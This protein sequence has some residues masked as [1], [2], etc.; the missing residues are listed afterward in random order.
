LFQYNAAKDA[1]ERV[2]KDNPNHA[3]VLQQLGWLYHQPSATFSNQ[4]TAISYLTKSLEADPADAKSWYLLGRAFMEGQK[5]NKAYEAYQQA[6][7]RDGKNPT[8]WCSIGVLYYQIN[9]YRDALDAYSR[10]IRLNP[11]ISE[12]WFNLGSLYE[13]CNNQVND[14]IDAYARA[15]DLDPTNTLIKTRLTMLRNAE[16]DGITLTDPPPPQDVHPTAYAQ[17]VANRAFPGAQANNG[18]PPAPFEGALGPSPEEAQPVVNGRDLAAPPPT[19]TAPATS[20]SAFRNGGGPPPLQMTSDIRGPASRPPRTFAPMDMDTR[21]RSTAPRP[22]ASLSGRSGAGEDEE[23]TVERT[24]A[25]SLHGRHES[26]Y[27]PGSSS[28]AVRQ[29]EWRERSDRA[30]S[31]Y[32]PSPRVSPTASRA[33]AQYASRSTL[34]SRLE[35]SPRS[36][37]R[38]PAFDYNRHGST[39]IDVRH[40]QPHRQSGDRLSARDVE[41][42]ARGTSTSRY[43]E[44]GY[45]AERLRIDERRRAELE[46]SRAR[47]E[48][49]RPMPT[50]DSRMTEDVRKTSR[51]PSPARPVSSH[52]RPG[53]SRRK[54]KP[55]KA[56]AAEKQE[57]EAE[58]ARR[59]EAEAAKA[60]PPK[61]VSPPRSRVIDEGKSV[62]DDALGFLADFSQTTM[63]VPPTLSWVSLAIG[64][65][66]K[67]KRVHTSRSSLCPLDL[68]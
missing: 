40:A 61:P 22:A 32:H 6:V 64:A 20:E 44:S 30:I 2:L 31:N 63:K 4:D 50:V 39:G 35:T 12:V 9:Q 66:D 33:Q 45:D 65:R 14:A 48:D 27:R 51:A 29:E 42:R 47:T 41:D 1:Y 57:R 16:R 15:H 18:N 43:S 11:F 8:F 49:E 26:A 52:S 7:Y 55:T 60:V 34:D 59:A 58:L 37:Q 46:Q 25:A 13:S 38:S 54:K 10:A 68:R 19:H 3:K 36:I 24:P 21:D 67:A 17:T 62:I 56:T 53:S 28:S 23:R 5:Y